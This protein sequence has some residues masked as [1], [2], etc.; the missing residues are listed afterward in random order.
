MIIADI[1]TLFRRKLNETLVELDDRTDEELML[2]LS[3]AALE[4]SARKISVFQTVTIGTDSSLSGY[5]FVPELTIAEA[6]LVIYK[7]MSNL[8]TL[9]YNDKISRGSLG[10]SWKSG[11]E[12]M[13]TI[14]ADKSW[15]GII[16]G[17]NTTLEELILIY[18]SQ[19]AGTRTQ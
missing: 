14:N 4:L 8:F 16:S 10:F 6:F 15:R 2:A 18:R 1:L 11:L 13:S 7:A 5:G 9:D 17:F 12:E 19:A 3:D